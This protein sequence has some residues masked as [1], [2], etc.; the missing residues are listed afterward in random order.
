[1]ADTFLG[2]F[3]D[4]AE[5]VGPP[6]E[7]GWQDNFLT[8]LDPV[9][10]L[11]TDEK[12]RAQALDILST[13]DQQVQNTGLTTSAGTA[14]A[15]GVDDYIKQV[16][17][18]TGVDLQ[19][20]WSG[21]YEKEAI[22]RLE[23]QADQL[24]NGGFGA[25]SVFNNL[26]LVPDMQMQIWNENLKKLQ[27]DNRDVATQ[28]AFNP[29]DV[30]RG[31]ISRNLQAAEQANNNGPL[32]EKFK[33][34][35]RMAGGIAAQ[36]YDPF[37]V[38]SLPLGGGAADLL[39]SGSN[40]ALRIGAE[41]FSQAAI[42]AGIS[43]ATMPAVNDWAART[44]Q[45]GM[46][47]A[48]IGYAALFGG[49]GGA[50][51]G[52][53]SEAFRARAPQ[54]AQILN[55]E[56]TPTTVKETLDALNLAPAGDK[57]KILEQAVQAERADRI[58][59]DDRPPGVSQAAH[60][61]AVQ[62]RVNATVNRDV[63]PPE[64]PD[65]LPAR[66]ADTLPSDRDGV[67]PALG[68][69]VER[70]GK[71][72]TFRAFDT[73]K[74]TTD[75]TAFQYKG[76]GDAA[77]VTERLRGVQTWD[78][79]AAGNSIVYERADGTLVIAD[80]HQ[81]LGLAKRISDAGGQAPTINGYLYR[82]ADGWTEADVRAYAALK[83][84]QEGSGTALD[85][86]RVLRDRPDLVTD[87]LPVSTPG[88]KQALGLSKLSPEAWGMTLNGVVPD[89]FAAAVGQLVPDPN[90][91]APIM[92]ELSSGKPANEQ[93]ARL[94][95]GD[96]LAQGFST[97]ETVD[98]FGS[99]QVTKSLFAERAAVTDAANKLLREDAKLFGTLADRADIIEAAGNKLETGT[100]QARADSA[101][102]IIELISRLARSVGPVSDMLNQAARSVAEAG[103]KPKAAARQFIA[104]FKTV[105]DR[106]GLRTLMTAPSLE[107]P[108]PKAVT[109]AVQR[110]LE[111][112]DMFAAP[113]KESP[114][115]ATPAKPAAEA[116]VV[117]EE[118]PAPA[119]GEAKKWETEIRQNADGTG[120][121][122]AADAANSGNLSF[123]VYADRV[124]GGLAV[125]NKKV[126]GQGLGVALYER[127]IKMADEMGLPWR[128]DMSVSGDADQVY[129]ALK[130]RGYDVQRN[131]NAVDTK[132]AK[133][134]IVDSSPNG[135]VYEVRPPGAT[136]KEGALWDAVPIGAPDDGNGVTMAKMEDATAALDRM[137]YQANLIDLC[138]LD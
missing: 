32:N 47:A 7:P 131:P 87:A 107:T 116:P 57:A 44:L 134:G 120:S 95:I 112:P 58:I 75:P 105:L 125:V 133:P 43:A 118:T 55:G 78:R 24:P 34:A 110:D 61:D 52:G 67:A 53:L 121:I 13:A 119:A 4:N 29:I 19:N 31:A 23:Q 16:K 20:P 37:M 100:N 72:V 113:A 84:M 109:E 62:Q 8:K 73:S 28:L 124:Q 14:I 59:S 123:K 33:G 115:A 68:H 45:P 137:D 111:T 108:L 90:L 102:T 126:R 5:N 35:L 138:T 99:S 127:A 15:R 26:N 36:R 27:R 114:P 104:D 11:I 6:L 129:Q 63:P 42:N 83:N 49:L 60:N 91:H 88:M 12:A 22:A 30:A 135:W 89:N 9:R 76:G 77:G 103:I 96:M 21:G 25:M 48:D 122:M 94:M 3:Q 10:Q 70:D 51:T 56:A 82:E 79:Q 106:D 92:R 18:L 80:G 50:V 136:A 54:V 38:G 93:Q 64:V 17:S 81:R 2:D 130:R 85:A 101:N 74:L 41:A 132:G 40:V 69:V 65:A 98:L 46:G 97:Q 1:M 66:P 128:S 86:A 39:Y 117:K 71:P